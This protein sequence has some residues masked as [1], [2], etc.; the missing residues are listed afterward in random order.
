[1]TD[2]MKFTPR[3]REFNV[4]GKEPV[5]M[6][7]LDELPPDGDLLRGKIDP[8]TYKSIKQNGQLQPILLANLIQPNEFGSVAVIDGEQRIKIQR[9]LGRQTQIPAIIY[10]D[11]LSGFEIAI[12]RSHMNN[13]RQENPIADIEAIRH[14]LSNYPSTSAKGIAV[15]TG[16]KLGRVKSMMKQAQMP[17]V[18]IDAVSDGTMSKDTLAD[19]SNKPLS[20]QRKAETKY[21]KERAKIQVVEDEETGKQ[22]FKRLSDEHMFAIPPSLLTQGDVKDFQRIS[23]ANKVQSSPMNLKVD[24]Q[25]SV[26]GFAA[27]QNGKFITDLFSTSDEVRLEV[28]RK[29]AT[30]VKVRSI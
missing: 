10:P 5:I 30:I 21:N 7:E 2:Q 4:T 3:I 13:A 11:E 18:F 20:V 25:E 28:G 1:M 22:V 26:E 9:Q 23:V 16:I 14:V 27:V 29:K 19:L 17:Q 12:L 8:D 15:M 6:Y 24:F